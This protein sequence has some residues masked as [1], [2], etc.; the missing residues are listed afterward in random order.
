MSEHHEECCSYKGD[1]APDS[2]KT[3]CWFG[4]WAGLLVASLESDRRK[5]YTVEGATPPLPYPTPGIPE[6]FLVEEML[7]LSVEM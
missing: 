6:S 1:K 3:S 4:K 7:N 2:G 5:E